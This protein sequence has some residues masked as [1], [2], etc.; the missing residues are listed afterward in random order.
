MS[1]SYR[2]L[3]L[4]DSRGF[5]VKERIR[6][7]MTGRGLPLEVEVKAFSGGT[8]DTV[9]TK[10]LFEAKYRRYD[11][12][13]LLAGVNNLTEHLGYRR[14]KPRFEQWSVMVRRLMIEFHI[15]RTRLYRLTDRV[16]V[17]D[18]IALNL[19]TYNIDGEGYFLH[20][21]IIN[22]A[23]VRINEYVEEMNR[24]AGVYSPRFADH[25]HKGRFADK[26]IHH[27][28]EGT[29]KDGLHYTAETTSKFSV[30]LLRG[31]L[32]LRRDLLLQ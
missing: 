3:L 30:L 4:A 5:K 28:Y 22:S 27:R 26:P 31:I 8:I 29:M 9:T 25:V 18:L 16:I 15:A 6:N 21:E 10:G 14:V 23:T 32:T 1:E 12:V 2:V 7:M 11:Q 17:C 20:Q 19:A 13:Y 24:D